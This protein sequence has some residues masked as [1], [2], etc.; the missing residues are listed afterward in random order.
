V[1]ATSAL[2]AR[3][4]FIVYALGTALFVSSL[5][6]LGFRIRGEWSSVTTTQ[7]KSGRW[8]M[9]SI[10]IYAISHVSTGLAWPYALR[11][12]DRPIPLNAG[13]KIGLVAQ[14]G[15]Y[16]PGNVAHY[17]GRA[18]L[19]KSLGVTVRASGLSTAVEIACALVAAA[20][21]APGILA[22]NGKTTGGASVFWVFA[23][24]LVIVPILVVALRLRG[25]NERERLRSFIVASSCITASLF[26]SGASAFALLVAL[27]AAPMPLMFV[28]SAFGLAWLAGFLTPG[29]PGGLGVRETIF[30]ALL[31]P[32]VGPGPALACAILHRVIT[33]A[34][35]FTAGIVGYAWLAS[36]LH[37][38]K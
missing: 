17:F 19:A 10:A 32:H 7:I 16:L 6:Y 24:A 30:V 21:L 1:T 12:V 11:V 27:G 18:A 15:K 23:A 14:V 3:A 9:A 34:V 28:A 33:A 36:G 38:K 35:D 31:T 8:M 4:K 22:L 13:I 20:L 25:S 5:V 29:A 2:S 26:L 37:S